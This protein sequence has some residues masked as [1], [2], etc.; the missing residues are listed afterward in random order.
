MDLLN[1]TEWIEDDRFILFLDF[2]KTFDMLE[3][4]FLFCALQHFVLETDL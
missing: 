2:K 1:Y 3:Y 4:S